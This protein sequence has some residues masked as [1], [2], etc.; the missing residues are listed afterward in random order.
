MRDF[1]DLNLNN[2]RLK[3]KWVPAWPGEA[4]RYLLTHDDAAGLRAASDMSTTLSKY[5]HL[6]DI[7]DKS[8]TYP[9]MVPE[10]LERYG[11]TSTNQRK[12]NERNAKRRYANIIFC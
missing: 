5:K 10:G 1:I 4:K 11:I 2:G 12:N 3:H 6:D 9:K 7:V 8:E